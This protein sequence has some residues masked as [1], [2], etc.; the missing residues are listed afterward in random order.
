CPD[1]KWDLNCARLCQNCEKPCDKFT[2]KCQQCKSGFQI[3][4]KSCTISCKHNQFGKDCRGNC[5]KKCGQDCVER[6]NGDCPSHS[7]GLLI[8][9][10]IAVIFVIVGIFIFIT[11]QR[12]RTQLAKPNENTVNS[13]MSE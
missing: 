3:P 10:I 13:E 2:G 4:E 5:L 1:F 8:G 9:I 11:V 6:I 7:A 12:K